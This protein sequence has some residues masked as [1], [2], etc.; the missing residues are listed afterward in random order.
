MRW[1]AS[2]KATLSLRTLSRF[3]RSS[4]CTGE[5][6]AITRYSAPYCDRKSRSIARKTS[7]SSSTLNRIGFAMVGLS[8]VKKKGFG[9]PH[10]LNN[11]IRYRNSHWS[12]NWIRILSKPPNTVLLSNTEFTEDKVQDILGGCGPRDLIETTQGAVKIEQKHFM[13]DF[14]VDCRSGRRKRRN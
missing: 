3:R 9:L 2:S 5:S 6:L 8:F 4:A 7:E 10:W 11:L 14:A 13:G 1:S 12:L